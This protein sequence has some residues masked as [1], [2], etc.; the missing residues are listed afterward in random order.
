MFKFSPKPRRI[1]SIHKHK[2][3]TLTKKKALLYLNAS[4]TDRKLNERKTF[5]CVEKQN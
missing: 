4:E 1:Q 2:S 5:S 3:K